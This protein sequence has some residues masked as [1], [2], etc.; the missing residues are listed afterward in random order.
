MGDL[1][2]APPPPTDEFHAVAV[3]V[4]PPP[5]APPP[6]PSAAA[7]N[8]QMEAQPV[9]VPVVTPRSTI[10]SF[11]NNFTV[12]TSKVLDQAL[13]HL[14]QQAPVGTG[15]GAGAGSGSGNG[16]FGSSSGNGAAGLTGTFFDFTKSDGGK[17]QPMNPGKY[18]DV[19]RAFTKGWKPPENVPCYKSNHELYS[20]FFFFPPIPDHDAGKAF[21]TN[22]KLILV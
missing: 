2:A 11:N 17:E 5:P 8:P 22:S 12:D 20:R 19:I 18:A 10:T 21:N 4:P 7:A 16:F 1:E 6:P 3:K 9:V 15:L 14:P 13:S